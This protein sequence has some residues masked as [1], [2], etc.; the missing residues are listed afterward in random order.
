MAVLF[1]AWAGMLSLQDTG[2][3]AW[4]HSPRHAGTSFRHRRSRVVFRAAAVR[5]APQW[6]ARR[7]LHIGWPG[8]W[9]NMGET[10][11]A[12]R[13]LAVSARGCSTESALLTP[14]LAVDGPHPDL[15]LSMRSAT[16]GP[17]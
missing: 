15:T 13:S 17:D 4:F 16:C 5:W 12:P 1:L 7:L 11:R 6:T 3:A 14:R 10:E 8:I 9:P 2:S